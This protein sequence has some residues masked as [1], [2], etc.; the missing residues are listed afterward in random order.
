[1]KRLKLA[2]GEFGRRATQCSRRPVLVLWFAGGD[3][4]EIQRLTVK[5][6]G[7]DETG[8][9]VCRAVGGLVCPFAEARTGKSRRSNIMG[10]WPVHHSSR[11]PCRLWSLG[12][13]AEWAGLA[14]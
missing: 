8:G 10:P 9:E 1:V 13:Q 12:R 5:E 11:P 14:G 7:W 4:D 3:G 6:A 2:P